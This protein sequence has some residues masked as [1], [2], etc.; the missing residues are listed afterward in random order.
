MRS[1]CPTVTPPFQ[2]QLSTR[3]VTT[4]VLSTCLGTMSQE[5]RRTLAICIYS[6]HY[7]LSSSSHRA[8]SGFETQQGHC[9]QSSPVHFPEFVLVIPIWILLLLPLN[10]DNLSILRS[11]QS[12]QRY[13]VRIPARNTGWLHLLSI[14]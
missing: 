13:P 5:L 6:P 12:R 7:C 4:A 14:S 11:G 10:Y 8:L 2:S 1:W 3:Q 9:D